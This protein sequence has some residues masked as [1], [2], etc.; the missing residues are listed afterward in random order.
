MHRERVDGR[1]E[2]EPGLSEDLVD[3]TRRSAYPSRLTSA[4]ASRS[5]PRPRSRSRPGSGRSVRCRRFEDVRR[6]DDD[7]VGEAVTVD[8]AESDRRAGVRDRALALDE[9][10]GRLRSQ[11][12]GED[13]AARDAATRPRRDPDAARVIDG[14]MMS[15]RE[16]AATSSEYIA[17]PT[18]TGT[19]SASG[20]RGS[21]VPAVWIF[22]G[23]TLQCPAGTE[24]CSPG[25]DAASPPRLGPRRRE[26]SC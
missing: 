14:C 23:G 17:T 12:G 13:S 16:V 22:R 7:H 8:V 2:D 15:L 20:P 5:R 11:R 10:V 4:I 24:A 26:P 25:L 21:H 19:C 6:P 9:R 1:A 18:R 3:A